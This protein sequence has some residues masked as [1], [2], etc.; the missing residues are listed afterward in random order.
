MEEAKETMFGTSGIRGVVNKEITPILAMRIGAALARIFKGGLLT[1]GRDTRTSGQMLS[2]AVAAGALSGGMGVADLGVLPTPA[3][4]YLTKS[5]KAVSGVM[6]TASHNPPE[7]NGLKLFD[8]EGRTYDRALQIQIE[9]VYGK[10]EPAGIDWKQLKNVSSVDHKLAYKKMILH[11]ISLQKR[12]NVAVDVGSG[13]AHQV[14]F[15]IL[16]SLQCRLVAVNAQPDGFFPGRNS[17]PTH[18]SLGTLM[19]TVQKLACDMGIAF[20][21]DADRV[22][23]VDELGRYIPGDV[24]LATFASHLVQRQK[25][26][27]VAIPIDSSLSVQEAIEMHGGRIVWT[28]VGDADVAEGIVRANALFG[29]EPSGAWIHPDFHL[30]PDGILSAILVMKAIEEKR[31][32]AHEFFSETPIYPLRRGKIPCSNNLKARVMRDLASDLPKALGE[33]PEVTE[34]DGVR[35]QVSSGWLLVRP[36]G[37]EPVIRL[38]VEARSEQSV[39]QLFKIGHDLCIDRIREYQA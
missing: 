16:R 31:I 26:G 28:K 21:G 5:L 11:R 3:L 38:T 18:E 34:L 37:T 7:F 29:G 15:D 30:C 39:E 32:S 22:S 33:K 36:S 2:A 13:A 25:G 14:A 12:W 4:A 35:I 23:F 24:A 6:V 27:T 9:N 20:D 17:E 1:L 8:R 19:I 10:D